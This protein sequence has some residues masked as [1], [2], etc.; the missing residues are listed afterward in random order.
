M[1]TDIILAFYKS[2][3]SKELKFIFYLSKKPEFFYIKISTNFKL[4][5]I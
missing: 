4:N 1:T 2:I 3:Y 5:R